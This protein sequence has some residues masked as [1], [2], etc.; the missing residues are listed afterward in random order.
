MID[1]GWLRFERAIR[2]CMRW[3]GRLPVTRTRGR[4]I[5]SLIAVGGLAIVYLQACMSPS[6]ELNELLQPLRDEF[7]HEAVLPP[8]SIVNRGSH[9]ELDY[10]GRLQAIIDARDSVLAENY[11][12]SIG[13]W[14]AYG[15]PPRIRV[16]TPTAFCYNPF[17]RV[18]KG[19]D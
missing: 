8:M 13:S 11:G 5:A 16:K 9:K 12:V 19:S 6:R 18:E 1:K 17:H 14:R 2:R 15:T 7:A 3:W 10:D 4:R